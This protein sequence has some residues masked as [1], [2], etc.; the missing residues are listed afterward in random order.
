MC[1][2]FDIVRYVS[3]LMPGPQRI[4]LLISVSLSINMKPKIICLKRKPTY[5]LF[6]YCLD[7]WKLVRENKRLCRRDNPDS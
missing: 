4:S 7:R 1:Y 3:D 5:K 6:I 2:G